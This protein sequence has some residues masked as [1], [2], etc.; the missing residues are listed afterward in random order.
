[1]S[2]NYLNQAKN[3][4]IEDTGLHVPPFKGS[5]NVNSKDGRGNLSVSLMDGTTA[6]TKLG[7]LDPEFRI[8]SK[9]VS[10]TE[11]YLTTIRSSADIPKFLL[12]LQG[13]VR[14]LPSRTMVDGRLCILDVLIISEYSKP[15]QRPI[16]SPFD[17]YRY[18][19]R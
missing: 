19:D 12:W 14:Y 4:S 18:L 13:K 3:D 6:Y 7:N 8:M 2:L 11:T 10:M 15:Y 1:M 5:I 17:L 16:L 9:S